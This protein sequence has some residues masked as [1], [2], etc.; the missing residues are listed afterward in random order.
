MKKLV[1]F[2]ACAFFATTIQAQEIDNPDIVVL[3]MSTID[4][5]ESNKTNLQTYVF[6]SSCKGITLSMAGRKIGDKTRQ[7]FSTGLNF[8]LNES[9]TIN[10]PEGVEM[11]GVQ[12]AGYSQGDNWDYLYAYGPDATEWEWT[13]PIGTGI[14]DNNTIIGSA[15]YSMDPC[16]TTQDVPV[17]NKAGYT[18]ASIDFSSEPYTGTFTFNCSGNNQYTMLIRVFTS[19]E[20]WDNYSETCKNIQYGDGSGT[21]I[22]EVTTNENVKKNDAKYN[23]S[24][25]RISTPNGLYITNGK[26]Y[27]KK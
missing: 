6:N 14:K 16:V 8:K 25:A 24:G 22:T 4:K 26:T 1:L 7:D 5:V 10:L 19:K 20:A 21:G 18:F 2:M 13:D 11:Y 17:Y 27:L 3:S 15:K 12:F 9:Y 23:I